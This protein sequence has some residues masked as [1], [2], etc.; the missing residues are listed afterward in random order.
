MNNRTV[1]W[2][3]YYSIE[4]LNLI[5]AGWREHYCIYADDEVWIKLSKV[6]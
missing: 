2:C 3:P 1:W 4:H 6:M 5:K